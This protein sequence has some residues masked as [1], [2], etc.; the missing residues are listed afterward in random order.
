MSVLFDYE[1]LLPLISSLYTLTGIRAD[2]YDREFKEVCVNE[3]QTP[4]FCEL[5]NAT[6]QGHER[7]VNCDREAQIRAQSGRPVFYRCHAG[8]CESILSI[9]Q[10]GEPLAYMFC[11]QYLDD[12]DPEE[13][14]LRAR[15]ALEWYPGDMEDLHRAFCKFRRYSREEIN[16]YSEILMVLASYIRLEGLIQSAEQTDLQRL[17]A[18]LDAHY[19]E[20]LSLES[21]ARDL[22]IGRTKLCALAKELSGGS[23]LSKMIT[24][25]R[26][27]EAKYLLRQ[28]GESVSAV[29]EAV[30]ISDYNYFTKVFR[31]STGMTPSEYRR[32]IRKTGEGKNKISQDKT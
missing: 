8:V 16:A 15:Q 3:Y 10:G 22:N 2:L 25:R 27:N 12:S 20:K 29:A 32:M 23:T 26:I 18:Y 4:P 30:G 14:W 17:E 13:Q 31:S 9:C 5:L 19:R 21:V 11:G 7:C 28:G 6:A 1:R 24:Q